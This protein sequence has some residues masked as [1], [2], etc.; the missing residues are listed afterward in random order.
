MYV[1][2]ISV[3]LVCTWTNEL[4]GIFYAHK[5]FYILFSK[6]QS[7]FFFDIFLYTY[8]Y[9][10]SKIK[11]EIY[12]RPGVG[13]EVKI[14]SKWWATVGFWLAQFLRAVLQLIKND[15]WFFIVFFM[16]FAKSIRCNL[17]AKFHAS[18]MIGI[19]WR[20]GIRFECF[21]NIYL[22][23]NNVR[24]TITYY[25]RVRTSFKVKQ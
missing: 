3:F 2:Q 21:R 17:V 12:A 16:K 14:K 7:G 25:M 8:I 5:I 9:L 19:R 6:S 10:N 18:F 15:R 23:C 11:F 20:R 4:R 24:C 13:T 22:P 1:F